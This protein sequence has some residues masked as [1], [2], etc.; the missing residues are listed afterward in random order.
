MRLQSLIFGVGMGLFL[1]KGKTDKAAETK[2]RKESREIF[3]DYLD[4][5]R[6]PEEAA[7]AA[8]AHYRAEG[9]VYIPFVARLNA[10][11]VHEVSGISPTVASKQDAAAIDLAMRGSVKQGLGRDLRKNGMDPV[12]AVEKAKRTYRQLGGVDLDFYRALDKYKDGKG[13]AK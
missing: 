10:M 13:P 2:R 6:T 11:A 8:E 7:H 4:F 9:G 1:L 3:Q 12:E 5:K